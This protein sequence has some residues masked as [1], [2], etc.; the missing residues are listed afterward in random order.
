M[1]PCS[2][3]EEE[4]VVGSS[5]WWHYKSNK[6]Y[7]PRQNVLL[8]SSVRWQQKLRMRRL[9]KVGEYTNIHGF[10]INGKGSKNKWGIGTT[11]EVL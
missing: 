7:A 11:G 2:S 3:Y 6:F 1:D 8:E 10:K 5:I 4:F 9:Q